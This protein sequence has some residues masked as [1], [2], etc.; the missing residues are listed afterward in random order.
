ML[1]P[2]APEASNY[3]HPCLGL[4]GTSSRGLLF[5]TLSSPS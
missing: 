2:N 5:I 4:R 3:V 1:S